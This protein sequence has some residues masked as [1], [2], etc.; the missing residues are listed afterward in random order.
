MTILKDLSKSTVMEIKSYAKKNNIDLLGSTKKID[1]LKIISNWTP[2]EE[3]Q[4]IK[5]DDQVIN[6]KLVLFSEKNIFWNGVGEVTKGYNVI[7]KEVSEKWLT[8]GSV[9]IASPQEVAS[10]YGK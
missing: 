4:E 8:H 5:K 2:K 6:E 7:T 9:R 10:Y 1:M 3:I